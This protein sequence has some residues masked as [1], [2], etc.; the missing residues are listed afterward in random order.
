M[1][2]LGELLRKSTMFMIKI[3]NLAKSYRWKHKNKMEKKTKKRGNKNKDKQRLYK[4]QA[5]KKL[6]QK[7]EETHTN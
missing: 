2:T 3:L 7:I 6:R 1:L 4:N 5:E